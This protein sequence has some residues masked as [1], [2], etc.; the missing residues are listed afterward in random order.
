M[1]DF[2]GDEGFGWGGDAGEVDCGCGWGC[3]GRAVA[4]GGEAGAEKGW[5]ATWDWRAGRDGEGDVISKTHNGLLCCRLAFYG[6]LPWKRIEGQYLQLFE[7]S[8]SQ[9]PET[10]FQISVSMYI[11]LRLS[12]LLSTAGPH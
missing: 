10:P 12:F 9:A 2:I 7:D 1:I 8:A 5:A 6:P 11:G 3:K 4:A